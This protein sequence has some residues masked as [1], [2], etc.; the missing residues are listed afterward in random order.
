MK[1]MVTFTLVITLMIMLLSGCGTKNEPPE[2]RYSSEILINHETPPEDLIWYIYLQS[3]ASSGGLIPI[4][5]YI[6]YAKFD[7]HQFVQ[8]SQRDYKYIL[9]IKAPFHDTFSEKISF[10]FNSK[11]EAQKHNY[12]LKV[13]GMTSEEYNKKIGRFVDLNSFNY[14]SDRVIGIIYSQNYYYSEGERNAEYANENVLVDYNYDTSVV[15]PYTDEQMMRMCSKG[16]HSSYTGRIGNRYYLPYGY[17]DLTTRKL[18]PY[19]NENDL[20]P[21]S[22]LPDVEDEFDLLRVIKKDPDAAKYI[23]ENRY[24]DAYMLVGDRYYVVIPDRNR[25]YI[26]SIDEY[27]GENVLFLTVDAA[28]GKVMYLE[29]VHIEN[30]WG[31]EYRLCQPGNDGILYD[32]MLP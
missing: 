18:C 13:L 6:T 27:D 10:I 32:V 15:I 3:P 7:E 30:Y 28:T 1:K 8:I 9:D 23:L 22:G 11:L 12:L 25:Y 4:P 19:K 31:Y 14:Y 17:Y 2:I 5:S 20:P 24:I 21:F 16:L 26:E 29:K